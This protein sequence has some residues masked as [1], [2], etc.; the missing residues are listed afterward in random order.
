M[1]KIVFFVFSIILIMSSSTSIWA[2]N[3]NHK[4]SYDVC[5]NCGKYN[6]H[7]FEEDIC[8]YTAKNDVAIMSEPNKGSSI[9]ET[10]YDQDSL[11]YIDGI[12]RNQHGNIWLHVNSENTGFIFINNIYLNLDALVITSY[13]QAT[14]LGLEKSLVCFYDLVRPGGT[15]DYKKW[16]DPSLKN[17]PYTVKIK[18]S[19]YQM[20]AEELGNIHYGYLGKTL[21]IDSEI[22]LYG[23]GGANII[24]NFSLERLK[25]I[26]ESCV[27]SYCDNE[28]DVYDVIRG[29]NYFESGEFN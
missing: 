7:E 28:D 6:L 17:I 14:A 16:L 10:M 13:Q 20:T 15:R 8:C 23:G 21:N 9:L 26:V 25:K 27:N 4:Y 19:F 3:C 1:K 12:L 24:S 22:L 11:I 2:K 5:I 29:I 18:D